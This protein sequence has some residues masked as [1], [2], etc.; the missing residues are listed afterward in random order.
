MST[1]RV[2]LP[3]NVS[4][5]RMI[6]AVELVRE[7]LMRATQALERAGVDYSVIG[8]N[9]V[10]AWVSTIDADA[11]RNTKDVDILIRRQDLEAVKAALA[12]VGF[13][14]QEVLGV[15]LFI[16]GPKGKPRQAVRAIFAGEFV[17]E[18]ELAPAADVAESEMGQEGFRVIRLDALLRLKLTSFRT[19][20]RVH[21]R[22]LIDIGLVDATWL[23][24]LPAEMRERLQIVLDNPEG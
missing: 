20:D 8:G 14:H 3:E 1:T 22:D 13:V 5:E 7:R 11:V 4:W 19:I 6:R 21:I 16:D 24:R 15:D 9:A 10:A 12:S 2:P 17:K 18:G 23:Q